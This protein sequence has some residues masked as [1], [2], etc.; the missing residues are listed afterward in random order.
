MSTDINTSHAF[1]KERTE[2]TRAVQATRVTDVP[3]TWPL[4][5][6]AQWDADLVSLDAAVQD[7]LAKVT[8]AL[9][10]NML[11]ARGLLDARFDAIHTF[12]L[13]A[14]GVMRV[15][16]ASLPGLLEIVND[17]SA[18]GDSRRTIEDE[19]DDLLA[20][21]EEWEEQTGAP[22]APSPGKTLAAF[23]LLLEGAA[24]VGQDTNPM[25]GTLKKTYK[26]ALA[27]WR[28]SVGVLNVLYSRLEDECVAWYAEATTVFPEGTAEGNLIRQ[29]IPTNYTPPA[30]AAPTPPPAPT[31]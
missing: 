26:A 24:G 14:V 11:T 21:W 7:S 22:F 1:V 18:R 17:L 9:N 16:A 8:A 23:K 31:P 27:K 19:A 15:R 13:L 4:K 28:R 30:P 5:T 6:L 29:E 3:W 10:A 12:T 25:L 2:K 20:A